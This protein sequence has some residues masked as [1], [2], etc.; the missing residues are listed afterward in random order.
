[1]LASNCGAV[2]WH[3]EQDGSSI[4]SVTGSVTGLWFQRFASG[5]RFPR[6]LALTAGLFV[7]DLLIPD[8]IPFADELLLGLATLILSRL[9]KRRGD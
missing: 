6:L 7:L 5:L 4:T 9:R 2:G 3:D 8:L 1:L